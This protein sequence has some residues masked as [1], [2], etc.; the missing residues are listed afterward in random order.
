MNNDVHAVSVVLWKIFN[1]LLFFI[2]NFHAVSI[3]ICPWIIR[4]KVIYMYIMF[5]QILVFYEK[6]AYSFQYFMNIVHACSANDKID[7]KV[8]Y[9]KCLWS[10]TSTLNNV[11]KGI[12]TR[13]AFLPIDL[14]RTQSVCLYYEIKSLFDVLYLDMWRNHYTRDVTT[15]N[16][17]RWK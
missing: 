14:K 7:L 1:E 5:K 13:S 9:G 16:M 3:V 12:L 4:L 15:N 2:N 10:D 17:T 11:Q 6:C 8:L